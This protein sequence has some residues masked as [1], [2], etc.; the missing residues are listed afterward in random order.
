MVEHVGPFYLR[1]GR[2]EVPEIY[3]ADT[4]FTVGKATT[5]R[6]GKDVT[7]IANGLMV[8]IALDAA[9]ALAGKGVNAR[10]ID[11]HTV[12]P[13]DDAAIIKAAAETGRIVVAEEHLMAGGL[14][15]AVASVVVRN[16]PVPM[17]FVN[18]GDRYAESGDPLGLLQKYG[19][20]SDAIEA[21]VERVRAR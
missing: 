17:E 6:D 20:T 18:V 16:K 19:L 3:G 9:A 12:K 14:G 21:A 13:L 5:L 8:G 2:I 1:C 11:M 10:V 15:S 7:I 4:P